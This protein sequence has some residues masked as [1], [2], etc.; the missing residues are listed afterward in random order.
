MDSDECGEGDFPAVFLNITDPLWG[1][2]DCSEDGFCID[3]D[4]AGVWWL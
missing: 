4:G 1:L 2:N 3:S